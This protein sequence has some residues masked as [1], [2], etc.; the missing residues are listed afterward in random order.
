MAWNQPHKTSS[1]P[2]VRNKK[3]VRRGVLLSILV[4]LGVFAVLLWLISG[5]S[6]DGSQTRQIKEQEKKP[7]VHDNAKINTTNE[8]SVSVAEK[9]ETSSIAQTNETT[10]VTTNASSIIERKTGY[11]VVRSK[12]KRVFHTMADVCIS[13]VINAKP[14]H[15]IIGTMNYDRFPD[16]LKK[17]LET[18][19]T[20]DKDDSD[21]DKELKKAVIETRK[22]LKEAM[23]RGEDVAQIMRESEQELRRL[24]QYRANL[25][26]ELGAAMR[27]NKYSAKDMQDYVDAANKLLKDNGMAPLKHPQLWIRSLRLQESQS[28]KEK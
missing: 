28:V 3:S 14:G 15:P 25:S 8:A 4:G 11:R 18:P 26:K 6:S 10:I 24:Y 13:R 17:A 21:E 2:P 22:E 27:E 7:V 19:I 12:A 1:I 23:D 9:V 16:L 20:I 5:D